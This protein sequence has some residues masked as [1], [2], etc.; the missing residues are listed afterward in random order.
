MGAFEIFQVVPKYQAKMKS[1]IYLL[2]NFCTVILCFIF[3]FHKR[4]RF[5]R[6]FVAFFKAALLVA[7]PFIGWDIWFTR[8][9]VWWFNTS[10]T[11]GPVIAGLPIEEWL[12]FFCIPFSCVFTF[13]CLDKFFDLRWANAYG[14]I[15]VF[16][17][18]IL[19]SVLALIYQAG[20]YTLVT[21]VVTVL[22][23]LFLHFV[24]RVHWLGM[25]S[26]VYLILMIGFFP[27]N[28]ILTGTGLETPV[29]NYNPDAFMGIRV[30][31]IP[32][33]DFIYGYSQFLLVIYFFKKFQQGDD[34]MSV[35]NAN[36]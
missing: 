10:Y 36:G 6:Q 22:V 18:V 3:S 12:F 5:N 14:T 17:L 1:Y 21:M 8:T 23:L 30:M 19:C 13:F 11:I 2:L 29:V 27:V 16:L 25:A 20:V 7:I 4:I 15:L 28:G 35:Q 26:L 9:G 34:Q 24:S 32:L 33:E 31:T